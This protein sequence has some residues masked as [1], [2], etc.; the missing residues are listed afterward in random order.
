MVLIFFK[1]LFW[2][3]ERGCRPDEARMK[4]DSEA[5]AFG[6]SIRLHCLY[7]GL[8]ALVH[9]LIQIHVERLYHDYSIN[10]LCVINQVIQ[11]SVVV[12]TLSVKN[13]II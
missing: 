3:V 8:V 7:I 6:L 13:L 4:K 2:I 5:L 9:C 11:F 12:R 10:I 1:G